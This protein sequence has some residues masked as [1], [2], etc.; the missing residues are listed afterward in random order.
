MLREQPALP[1]TRPTLNTTSGPIRPRSALSGKHKDFSA[2]QPVRSESHKMAHFS[3]SAIQPTK[4]HAVRVPLSRPRSNSSG[5]LQAKEESK[6]TRLQPRV[7]SNSDR[8]SC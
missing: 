2:S 3:R 6:A 1:T 7:I 8:D 4:E 5:S